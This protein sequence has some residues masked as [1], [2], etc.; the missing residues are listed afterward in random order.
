MVDSGEAD[1]KIIGVL[2]GDFV[3]G[4]TMDVRQL[5][6]ILMERLRHYFLT[7]KLQPG[8]ENKVVIHSIYGRGQ[9]MKVIKASMTDYRELFGRNNKSKRRQNEVL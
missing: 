4:E 6:S 1:D 8:M 5:P 9:A 3:W 2:E 7:Y